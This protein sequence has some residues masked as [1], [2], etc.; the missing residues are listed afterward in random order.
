MT[1]EIQFFSVI[2]TGIYVCIIAQKA[3]MEW[4]L[5]EFTE[6]QADRKNSKNSILLL[7]ILR[8]VNEDVS[9]TA[10]GGVISSNHLVQER[11]ENTSLWPVSRNCSYTSLDLHV[12]Q[13]N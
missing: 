11:C 9:V 2:L 8:F 4:H 1:N 12:L 3:K 5:Q 7:H 6:M 13:K 10:S